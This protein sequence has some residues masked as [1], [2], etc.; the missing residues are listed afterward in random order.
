MRGRREGRRRHRGGL[1]CESA[2]QPASHGQTS[3]REILDRRCMLWKKRREEK[4]RL[5]PHHFIDPR[6]GHRHRKKGEYRVQV[7][8]F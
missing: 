3:P 7:V 5:V 1:P 6:G 8:R 2:E 4:H